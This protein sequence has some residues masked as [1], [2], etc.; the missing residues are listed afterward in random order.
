MHLNKRIIFT[1]VLISLFY[2]SVL[3]GDIKYKTISSSVSHL[4]IE[5]EFD[6]PDLTREENGL[7]AAYPS[8][9]MVYGTD[10]TILPL[11]TKLFNLGI[12]NAKPAVR[13]NN[14]QYQS[15]MVA[16]YAVTSVYTENHKYQQMSF[17]VQYLGKYRDLPLYA[18][19]IIPI[20]YN[21]QTKTLT[22][23]KQVEIEISVDNYND[24]S[25]LHSSSVPVKSRT[26]LPASAILNKSF[27]ASPQATVSAQAT[28][29][30]D[31]HSNPVFKHGNIYKIKVNE[32]GLYKV[33]YDDLIKAGYPVNSVNPKKLRLYNKGI[34]I[35][36]YFYGSKDDQFDE[37][38][39]FE[40]WGEKTE[41]TFYDTYPEMWTDP[42]TD[43]NVYWLVSGEI[44]GLRMVEESGSL[45]K[46]QPGSFIRPR[47]FRETIHVEKNNYREAL[48]HEETPGL[49]NKYVY[50]IDHWYFDSGIMAVQSKPYNFELYYPYND[51]SPN[52]YVTAAFRG[53]SI[54]DNVYHQLSLW[55]N[56]QHVG[57]ITAADKWIYQQPKFLTNEGTSGLLQSNLVHGDNTLRV[58][59]VQTGVTD[60]VMLNWFNVTYKREY[61]AHD[62]F[63]KFRVQ[64]DLNREMT[65]Q[66][67]IAGFST[68]DIQI[69]KLGIS[70]IVNGP[71]DFIEDT[72]Y[73]DSYRVSFQDDIF[74]LNVRYIALTENNKKKP[75]S[76]SRYEYWNS[77][78]DPLQLIDESNR[79][80]YLII[81][82]KDFE[83][84]SNRIKTLKESQS[85]TPQVVMVDQIYDIF[86]HGI[87]SPLAIK[88]F[89]QYVYENWDKSSRLEYVVLVGDASWD[90]KTSTDLIPTMLFETVKYGSS[91]AD[92]WYSLISGDDY[93]PDVVVSRIPVNN[94]TDLNNYIAKI[95][96]YQQNNSASSWRNKA[97]FISGN[98]KGTEETITQKPVFRAQNQRIINQQLPKEIFCRKLNTIANE[99]LGEGKDPQF[100]STTD[101]IEYF[102]TGLS[103]MNFFGHGGGAI[104]SDV[105][106]MNV[107]D[108]NRLNNVDQY[109]FVASMTCYTGAF[110]SP[111][112]VSLAEKMLLADR[113][114][115][116]GLLASS[117][118]G[119]MYNDMA[120]GWSL[121]DF[122]WDDDLTFGQ[123]VNL[124]KI[125]Y[126]TDPTYF[127]DESST[128][129][130]SFYQLYPSMLFQYN[131]LGDPAL[132]IQKPDYKLN[133]QADNQTPLPNDT[134]SI[135][136]NS[137][138]SGAAFNIEIVDPEGYIVLDSELEYGKI[139]SF[140]IPDSSEGIKYIVKAYQ[141]NGTE[142]AN[143]FTEIFVRYSLIKN[144]Y[145][146]PVS[147]Q[148][149]EPIHF[150]VIAKS[151]APIDTMF[152]LNF[153][154]VR[155]TYQYYY[156]DKIPM[157]KVND[158]LFQSVTPFPGF[159]TG[160]HK[161]FDIFVRTSENEEI[162]FRWNKL[163]VEDNRPELYI[164]SKSL[165]YTGVDTLKL[166]C[167]LVNESDSSLSNVKLNFYTGEGIQ[168]GQPFAEKV[169]TIG[170]REKKIVE[171]VFDVQEYD[172]NRQFRIIIDKDNVITERN[173]DNNIYNAQLETDH[174]FIEK[175]I[176][177]S[178]NKITNDTLVLKERWHFNIAKGILSKSTVMSFSQPEADPGDQP[179]ITPLI[180]DK[181][182]NPAALKL[183]FMNYSN[184]LDGSA[185]LALLPE[186]SWISDIVSGKTAIYKYEENINRWVKQTTAMYQE[187]MCAEVNSSGIY[188]VFNN[189][190]SEDP[191]IEMTVNGQ[192]I[193]QNMNLGRRPEISLI[194]QDESGIDVD[195]SLKVYIDNTPV[196]DDEISYPEKIQNSNT[197]SVLT[198][199]ELEP[200]SHV[201]R[202]E[203]ADVN[204]NST[205]KEVAVQ[206][207]AAFD[208]IVYGNFPNPFTDK[209]R[210]AYQI[211]DD[212]D[213][214]TMK[215][216]S[217]SGRLIR[218]KIP[219]IVDETVPNDNILSFGY[220]EIIWDGTDDDGNQVANGVYFCVVSGTT[221]D[222][223]ISHTFKIARLR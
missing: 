44:N 181:T 3:A 161:L 83:Y 119:W 156:A 139:L 42:F 126:Q 20:K 10:G 86:N 5:A 84:N 16:D 37:G 164:K 209:T 90:Y 54:E 131:L 219:D 160:G 79:C 11:I 133:V 19:N 121:Y 48:G 192:N 106:L 173:E 218:Q 58:D 205:T 17:V 21:P 134:V 30:D 28:E 6:K 63:L 182:G 95:E 167:T 186:A 75:L 38:D 162:T 155:N 56:T 179:D 103:F 46:T 81:T 105:Q 191:I 25:G 137:Q 207:A 201:I 136:V 15:E 7:V 157:S 27:Y 118:L 93:I 200:G 12:E 168:S 153:K 213:D 115:A 124:M 33:T 196:P 211:S 180:L 109:P 45:V 73:G 88:D 170:F 39:F 55:L 47:Y 13:L 185:Y 206:V 91:S 142:D 92:F 31:L 60:W 159:E 175:S 195:Q 77:E 113:K 102:D 190:D 202:V 132:K 158:S 104:W 65:P 59:M 138:I 85:Y 52:V 111:G 198:S 189:S 214:L 43:I 71:V 36:V 35:P 172:S 130:Y 62:N 57:E 199:P 24:I 176:G 145:T 217:T 74:D 194:V 163:Y 203:V 152:L 220:H 1:L 147:P 18:L 223:K 123:S 76:I 14:V 216:Y 169:V 23:I 120:I 89:I 40:F 51:G 174:L 101:L 98:D 82:H 184:L 9:K 204:G 221:G 122:L 26:K 129:T 53:R 61:R 80:D 210:I 148:V 141:T 100:G 149:N 49:I 66:F 178:L 208:F 29:L 151:F 212:L 197:I 68:N 150:Q 67:E 171:T 8:A 215:I 112:R 2:S 99:K 166:K 72:K 96:V 222:K 128:T 135:S 97:L 165:A 116:I 34:E 69:Y 108:V 114:G 140:A 78:I 154:E 110:E 41:K 70:K 125:F 177:T 127:F 188:T 146:N 187:F 117:G 183:E 50:E 22:W 32:D 193:Y 4:K 144:F 64:P 143:G 87:K 107:A 94:N